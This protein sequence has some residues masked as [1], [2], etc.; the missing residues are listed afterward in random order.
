MP[1]TVV[2]GLKTAVLATLVSACALLLFGSNDTGGVMD[3]GRFWIVLAA[4]F[5]GG[6]LGGMLF[7]KPREPGA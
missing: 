7:G 6:F 5:F 2:R 1:P 4:V 3:D